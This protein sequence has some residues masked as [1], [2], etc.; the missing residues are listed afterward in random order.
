M[1]YLGLGN[2]AISWAQPLGKY[3]DL[4]PCDQVCRF[5][6]SSDIPDDPSV[7][8]CGEVLRQECKTLKGLEHSQ[9][10]SGIMAIYMRCYLGKFSTCSVALSVEWDS[11]FLS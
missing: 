9:M 1:V 2:L 11:S 4:K 8:C 10:G 3:K 7:V 5:R 6:Y